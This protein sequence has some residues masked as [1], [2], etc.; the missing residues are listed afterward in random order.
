MLGINHMGWFFELRDAYGT[1][2]YPEVRRRAIFR[3]LFSSFKLN[4]PDIFS[5]KIQR[6]DI[7]SVCLTNSE[8]VAA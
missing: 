3:G 5:L 7:V 4:S 2:F 8:G 1:D 6:G